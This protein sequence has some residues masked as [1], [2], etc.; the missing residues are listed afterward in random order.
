MSHVQTYLDDAT[1]NV[2]VKLKDTEIVT[3]APGGEIVLSTD[4]WFTQTTL[5][6]T[7]RMRDAS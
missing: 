7:R 2:V 5:G 6:E 3:V 1:G 4:G